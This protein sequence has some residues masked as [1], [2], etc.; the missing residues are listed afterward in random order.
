MYTNRIDLILLSFS[1]RQRARRDAILH[2]KRYVEARGAIYGEVY[3]TTN[4]LDDN[5]SSRYV[6]LSVYR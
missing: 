5:V 3:V 2:T 1:M 6:D 4:Q